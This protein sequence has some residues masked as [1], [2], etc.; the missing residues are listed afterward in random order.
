MSNGILSYFSLSLFVCCHFYFSQCAFVLIWI[1][2][3]CIK[4]KRVWKSARVTKELRTILF[5]FWYWNYQFEWWVKAIYVSLCCICLYLYD[6]VMC[7][8]HIPVG[9]DFQFGYR[10]QHH[11]RKEITKIKRK[12]NSSTAWTKC[13]NLKHA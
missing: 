7:N 11:I 10:P 5:Q 12:K 6:C 1:E 2:C 9:Y 8:V 3:I 4:R 13:E